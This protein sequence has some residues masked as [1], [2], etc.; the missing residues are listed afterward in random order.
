MPCVPPLAF[1]RKRQRLSAS[2]RSALSS[3]LS[4]QDLSRN[5]STLANSCLAMPRL[6]LANW[7]KTFMAEE[8]VTWGFCST[9]ST[10]LMIL[11]CCSTVMSGVGG[12]CGVGGSIADFACWERCSATISATCSTRKS[13]GSWG[14]R[15]TKYVTIS[16][17]KACRSC[18]SMYASTSA[19]LGMLF[20]VPA[21]LDTELLEQ[22]TPV[23]SAASVPPMLSTP[24]AEP[25][26]LSLRAG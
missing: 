19:L 26:M 20:P 3:L 14:M 21:H 1:V 5:A 15:R 23:S 7:L 22:G 11:S 8:R 10:C 9:A 17:K 25:A 6:S 16:E 12:C 18:F 24:G 13:K 4:P 2:S